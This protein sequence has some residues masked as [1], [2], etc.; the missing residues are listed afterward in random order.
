[1]MHMIKV[2]QT[3]CGGL[4]GIYKVFGMSK[5]MFF[6]TVFGR[7]SGYKFT[8]ISYSVEGKHFIT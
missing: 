8:I 4:W 2:Q 6:L 5:K 3:L 7:K 1:M